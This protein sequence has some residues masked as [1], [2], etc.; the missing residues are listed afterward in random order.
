[1]NEWCVFA[2][3]RGQDHLFPC[4]QAAIQ[5]WITE[6]PLVQGQRYLFPA[7][8]QTTITDDQHKTQPV[9]HSF[10]RSRFRRICK[11]AGVEGSHAHIHTTDFTHTK[12]KID[13]F[14]V[15]CTSGTRWH[16]RCILQATGSQTHRVDTQKK[17]NSVVCYPVHIQTY[18]G[19][20]SPMTTLSV[21]CVP[22]FEHLISV[23]QLPWCMSIDDPGASQKRC[24]LLET[25]VPPRYRRHVRFRSLSSSVSSVGGGG[26]GTSQRHGTRMLANPTMAT[27]FR[28]RHL[29]F[30]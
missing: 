24:L 12:K 9:S 29:L 25:L 2:Q 18:M 16:S 4:V 17:K 30:W 27:S 3:H 5:R 8:R 11:R 15:A 6:R 23:L 13:A 20:A 21:Y 7:I 26:G 1:M 28:V 22:D 10:L 14:F 19:H